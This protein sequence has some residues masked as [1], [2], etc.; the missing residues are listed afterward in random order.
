MPVVVAVVVP[1]WFGIAAVIYGFYQYDRVHFA[2]GTIATRTLADLSG[3]FNAIFVIGSAGAAILMLIG[4][5][6]AGRQVAQ[7]AR[8]VQSLIPPALALGRGEIANVPQSNV[9]EADDI[10]QALARASTLLEHLRREKHER[11]RGEEKFRLVVESAPSAMVMI[12]G[13]GRIVLVNAEAEKLFGYSRD[14]LLGQAIEM[15]VPERF[16]NNHP[17]FRTSFFASPAARSM[18]VGRDLHGRRKNGSEFPVE[19]GLN[20]IETEEGLL[21][22][23]AIVDITERKRAEEKFRLVVESAPSAM[24]MINGEGRIVLVNAEAEKLFGYTREELLDQPI[25]TL[26]PERFR[27][28]HPGFRTSFFAS[29]AARS[30]GV[31]R[32]L[33]G[34]RKNGSEF[35]VEIGLNPIETEEGLLV[36]SAIVDLTERKRAEEKFRLVVESSPNA[37]VMINPKGRIVLINAQTEKLFGYTREELLDQPIETLVPERFRNNHPEF[38]TSFFASPAARLMGIGRDLHGR[39]KD[40]SE[41]PVEIG[42]NPIQTQDG[43][44]VLSAIVDLTERKRAEEKILKFNEVLEQRVTERTAQLE[45]ANK[46]LEEFA[47][48]ASHD[49]KA[50]LRVIDNTSKWLEDDLQ[51]HLTD[52]T[53]QNM[54]LLRGRVKRMEKLLD[55]LLEYSRIGRTLDDRY[56]ETIGGDALMINIL[57]LLSPPEGFAVTTSASFAGIQVRRM[58]LQQILMN[59]ISNAIKH[60]DKKLGSIDVTVE[61]CGT[62]YSFAVKDDGPGI[63]AEYQDQIF[64]M[65]LTLKPRDQV[66]GSGMGLAMVRKNIEVFGGKLSLESTVGNGSVFRFTWPKHQKISEKSHEYLGTA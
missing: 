43:L 21:V 19:I 54:N 37:M 63:A 17:G 22:L 47:Y 8:A 35:P 12:N 58:P 49:L 42:L 36:L 5:A 33:Y 23:S 59:L 13:D 62:D 27:S 65:F 34:R 29:P 64:K 32:D 66:E 7:I 31:G 4:L 45:I 55:D 25:E 40:G 10:A 3:G 51:E 18:G 26:V 38:R 39:R 53:R 20:P 15:L 9:R 6:L 44:H 11:E 50:P 24:V 14:E 28:N 61:D 1:G 48:A 16:R 46:E 41:F 60:H 52:E 56:A 57:G 2:Q 30:M